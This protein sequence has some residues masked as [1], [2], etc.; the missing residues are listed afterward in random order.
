MADLKIELVGDAIIPLKKHKKKYQ[1]IE[2]AFIDRAGKILIA[3]KFSVEDLLNELSSL[4]ENIAI[5]EE[6]HYIGHLKPKG[7]QRDEFIQKK[8]VS[9][10]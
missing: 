10:C 5:I 1:I 9:E 6:A 8:A 4:N 3:G 2:L 7:G